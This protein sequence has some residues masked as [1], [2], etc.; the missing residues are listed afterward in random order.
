MNNIHKTTGILVTSLLMTSPVMM[1]PVLATPNSDFD[2]YRADNNPTNFHTNS[3]PNSLT[4]H[5]AAAFQQFV[6]T[7]AS[8]L[9]LNTINARR[10]DTTRLELSSSYDV[11]VYFINESA[12]ARNQL[13]INSTG[14]TIL[15]GMVFYDISCLEAGCSYPQSDGYY[16]LNPDDVLELGDYIS[17]GTVESGSK[18]DFE[19]ISPPLDYQTTTQV[20]YS[21]N[22]LNP[23][24]R[25]VIAYEYEGY[26]ILSWEDYDD[27][28]YNDLV[29][30]IDIGQENLDCI[31]TEGEISASG[32]NAST[33]TNSNAFP[34]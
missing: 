33:N 20:L 30:A 29:F 12:R 17:V 21:D 24:D 32:C 26:L 6:N 9:D 23:S 2:F 7:E 14:N 1:A 5:N 22:S 31:P 18:L 15:T 4:G 11:K 8:A 13:R 10:L 19:L 27:A 16:T 3:Y 28:D 34:D 25:G